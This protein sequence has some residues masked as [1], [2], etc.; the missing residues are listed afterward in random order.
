M[1]WHEMTLEQINILAAEVKAGRASRTCPPHMPVVVHRIGGTNAALNNVCG[2]CG[3]HLV[4]ESVDREWTVSD[5]P[6]PL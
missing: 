3:E 4:R 5:P 2:K 1:G 6:A